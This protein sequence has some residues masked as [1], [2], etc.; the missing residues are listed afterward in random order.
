MSDGETCAAILSL[1]RRETNET[2]APGGSSRNMPNHQHRADLARRIAEIPERY[3]ESSKSTA[4]LLK[5]AGFPRARHEIAVEEVAAVLKAEPELIELWMERG[6]DQ[7]LGGGWG[8]EEEHQGYR[9]KSFGS[10]ESRLIADRIHACAEFIVHYVGFIGETLA[11]W[12][13]A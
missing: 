11:K 5:D 7:R 13:G 9:I 1:F 4:C 10:G 3:E 6:A 12:H 8:I 2:T